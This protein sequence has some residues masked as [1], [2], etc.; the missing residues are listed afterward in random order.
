MSSFTDTE[1][2]LKCTEFKGIDDNELNK[3]LN[4]LNKL[5]EYDNTAGI[6]SSTNDKV[7]TVT[8]I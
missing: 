5:L 4:I 3:L 7:S 8:R 2:F 6:V 1:I